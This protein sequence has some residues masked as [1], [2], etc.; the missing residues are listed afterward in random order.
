MVERPLIET[1]GSFERR[2]YLAAAWVAHESIHGLGSDPQRP[3]HGAQ[4]RRKP[5]FDER[6]HRAGEDDPKTLGIDGPAHDV[7]CI[8]PVV[9]GSSLD[10]SQPGIAGSEYAG[11]ATVSE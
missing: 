6:R 8:S 4:G 11:G 5:L 2:D 1:Q 7:E 3:Q 10:L 9:L